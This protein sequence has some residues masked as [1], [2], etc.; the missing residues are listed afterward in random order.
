MVKKTY[1]VDGQPAV[2]SWHLEQHP[3]VYS[4]RFADESV[5]GTI[6][7]TAIGQFLARDAQGHPLGTFGLLREAVVQVLREARRDPR[8]ARPTHPAPPGS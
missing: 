2:V 3:S 6:A 4:V 7:M 8:R 5:V 1:V